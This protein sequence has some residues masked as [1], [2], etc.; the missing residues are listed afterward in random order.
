MEYYIEKPKRV[1]IYTINNVQHNNLTD[2]YINELEISNED[3]EFIKKEIVRYYNQLPFYERK[4]RDKILT[5]TD[6]LM[7]EDAT[8]SG[9]EIR[10]TEKYEEIKAYRKALREY[11]FINEDRPT[12]PS[13]LKVV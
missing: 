1:Y 8:I 4:W 7:V 6:W 12:R 11:D 9:I 13:W 2:E 5:K 3:K 10:E